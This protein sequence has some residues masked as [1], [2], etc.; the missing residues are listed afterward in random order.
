MGH[1]ATYFENLI[2][3]GDQFIE[4]QRGVRVDGQVANLVLVHVYVHA[5]DMAGN[6]RR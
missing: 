4:L 6:K 3:G 5:L 2:V 1:R